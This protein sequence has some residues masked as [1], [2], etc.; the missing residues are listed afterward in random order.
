ML[1]EVRQG[2]IAEGVAALVELCAHRRVV[3]LTGAG[4]STESGIPDYRG[5]GTRARAK[6]PMRFAE[7]TASAEGR[8]RYWA[9]AAVG[10]PSFSA[11]QPNAGHRA[12]A[13]LEHAGVIQG[14]ITQNVDE[15]HQRAGTRRLIELHG[16][17]HAV[18]CLTCGAIE[19]RADV[20][21]RLA[22]PPASAMQDRE[23]LRPDGDAELDPTWIAGFVAPSCRQCD[24][25][26]KP[27]VVYFGE[28]V[29]PARVVAAY[30]WVEAAEV[31]LVV[32][33][34]LTVFSGYRFVRR[35]AD[36]GTPI[37]LVNLGPTRGDPHASLRVDAS[38][39]AVLDALARA[40]ISSSDGSSATSS[41]SG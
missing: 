4:I 8:A 17:L 7:F 33:S 5:P 26:L 13:A 6:D 3:A 35:A 30:E 19:P 1:G 37:A 20:Q 23:R 32:G 34:S 29:P 21:Q 41:Y 9:R 31:L 25:V 22:L 11:A 38:A 39:G 28:T 10:W 12:V 40:L 36:R 24:G 27:D 2:V 18:R 16:T 15:L 14:V